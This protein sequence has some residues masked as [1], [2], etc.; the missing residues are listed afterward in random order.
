MHCLHGHVLPGAVQTHTHQRRVHRAWYGAGVHVRS[1]RC[2]WVHVCVHGNDHQVVARANWNES[3]Q[4]KVADPFGLQ[5]TKSITKNDRPVSWPAAVRAPGGD[6]KF[7]AGNGGDGAGVGNGA[8]H[9]AAPPPGSSFASAEVV[10]LNK[11]QQIR[12]K[13]DRPPCLVRTVRVLQ[14]QSVAFR[15]ELKCFQQLAASAP[16]CSPIDI[17]HTIPDTCLHV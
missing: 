10:L 5:R 15:F 17:Y 13:T 1:Y 12:M 3:P 11:I 9:Q 7:R 6:A 4:A 8:P 14:Y 2:V 16:K